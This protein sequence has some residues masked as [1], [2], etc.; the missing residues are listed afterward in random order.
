MND[1]S[2][3]LCMNGYNVES[4]HTD[5][6]QRDREKAL[7]KLHNDEVNILL[8]TNIASREIDIDDI[9]IVINYDFINDIEEYVYRVGQ[10]GGAVN[11]GLVITLITRKNW[12]KM[13]NNFIKV[14]EKSGQ[15]IPQEL[16][17]MARNFETKQESE[18]VKGDERSIKEGRIYGEKRF[19]GGDGFEGNRKK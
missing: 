2:V 9:K 3:N 7:K 13:T 15:D 17:D 14:M 18:R 11:T 5:Y 19:S 8:A 12:S 10:T 1:I 16:H 6:E 4:I